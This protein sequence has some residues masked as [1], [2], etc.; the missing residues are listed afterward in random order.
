MSDFLLLVKKMAENNTVLVVAVLAVIA[1]LAA[2]GFSYYSLS[3][4][5]GVSGFASSDTGTA[6]LSVQ[7]LTE[8][9]F[10]D[11]TVNWGNLDFLAGKIRAVLDTSTGGVG[12]QNATPTTVETTGLVLENDGNADASITLAAGKSAANFIGGT[13]PVY[14]WTVSSAGARDGC[15]SANRTLANSTATA[16][17]DTAA[18]ANLRFADSGDQMR[19]DFWLV[20]PYDT[21]RDAK[22]DTITAKATAL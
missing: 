7:T 2:A 16:T 11:D 12:V 18:C 8:I 21:T 15:D 10:I 5:P 3:K 19:V 17:G 14:N 4:G 9:N 20:V 1:S 13:G 22:S 6:S